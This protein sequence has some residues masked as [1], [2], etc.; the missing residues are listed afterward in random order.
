[1]LQKN[2]ALVL[3]YSS[4]FDIGCAVTP[5]CPKG[6]AERKRGEKIN[7]FFLQLSL[8]Q[9]S[10]GC[11]RGFLSVQSHRKS[12]LHPK[13]CPEPGGSSG[14]RCPA[15]LA[16]PAEAAHGAARQ[17]TGVPAGAPEQVSYTRG[18]TGENCSSPGSAPA[19][20]PAATLSKRQPEG[21]LGADFLGFLPSFG[22]SHA[23]EQT[24][25]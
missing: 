4:R 19:N 25:F 6:I 17:S 1:M 10:A 21:R 18:S 13:L 7:P 15:C 8:F 16:L 3:R 24:L 5:V 11:L 20:A 22:W 2:T 23:W 14:Y 9:R 12:P